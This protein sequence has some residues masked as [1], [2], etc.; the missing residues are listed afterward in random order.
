MFIDDLKRLCLIFL[1]LLWTTKTN[2]HCIYKHP[3][4]FCLPFIFHLFVTLPLSRAC[5]S[6]LLLSA[7]FALLPALPVFVE[8]TVAVSYPHIVWA[9]PSCTANNWDWCHPFIII[10]AHCRHVCRILFAVYSSCWTVQ[11]NTYDRRRH[12][13]GQSFGICSMTTGTKR[14]ENSGSVYYPLP[15]CSFEAA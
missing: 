7:P 10:G 11:Y 14:T 13:G 3:A 6:L 15:V 4:L 9:L 12:I 5:L 1:K 2:L 8:N